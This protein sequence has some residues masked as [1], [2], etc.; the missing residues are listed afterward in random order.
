MA[1]RPGL[2]STPQGK[3]GRGVRTGSGLNQLLFGNTFRAGSRVT[4]EKLASS[5]HG[6]TSLSVHFNAAGVPFSTRLGSEW[7]S[8]ICQTYSPSLESPGFA[9]IEA[10][11]II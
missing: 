6:H 5:R 10:V 8:A 9:S 11:I 4:R 7:Y 3:S 2:L 1:L